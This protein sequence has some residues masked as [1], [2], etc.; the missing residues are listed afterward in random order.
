LKKTTFGIILTCTAL[1][2]TACGG[3]SEEQESSISLESLF[4]VLTFDYTSFASGVNMTDVVT[5]TPES[6]FETDSGVTLLS[7]RNQNNEITVCE[8]GA[9]VQEAQVQRENFLCFIFRSDDTETWFSF[10]SVVD[11]QG[12]GTYEGCDNSG[13]LNTACTN[14]RMGVAIINS[15]DGRVSVSVE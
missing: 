15:F 11:G 8:T 1:L 12:N 4:G 7:G 5:F 13:D 10:S 3:G 9:I 14:E 2:Q 6:V